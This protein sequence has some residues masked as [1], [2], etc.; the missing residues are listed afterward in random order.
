MKMSV[1]EPLYSEVFRAH[2]E[3]LTPRHPLKESRHLSKR[4]ISA[5]FLFLLN[6]TQSRTDQVHVEDPVQKKPKVP[7][8]L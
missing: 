2:L 3:F 6:Q 8:R 5:D 1:E 7:T 4:L